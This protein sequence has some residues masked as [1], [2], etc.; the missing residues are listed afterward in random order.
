MISRAMLRYGTNRSCIRELFEYGKQRR[1]VV[2]KENVYDFS[3]GNPSVPAPEEVNQAIRDII[4]EM[5]ST[6]IHGYTSGP[7]SNEARTAIINNLNK[8]FGTDY[9]FTDL[10]LTAGAAAALTAA[11]RALTI[12]DKTEFIAFAP[13][14]TEYSCFAT[15]AGAKLIA[16]PADI[17]A[18]QINFDLLERSI[19]VNTQGVIVNSPNNPSGVIYTEETIKELAALL[20]KKSEEFGHPIF[21]I[22]DEPYRELVYEGS[23]PFIPHYYSNTIICYSYSKSL[24]LPGERIGYALVPGCVEEH[25]DVYGAIAGAGR[26]L[27]YVCAPSLMQ[28]VIARCADVK[29]DLRPYIANRELIYNGLTEMGYNCAKPS[30]AFYLFVEA[31]NGDAQ[32]FSDMAKQQ[33]LLIVPGNDFGCSSYVRISYCVDHEMIK[34]SLPVFKKLMD[35]VRG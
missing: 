7:G 22:S 25:D 11:F 24:S 9:K 1:L 12:D 18:F 31:P 17:P 26:A 16:V 27:G 30:G 4:E 13:F 3:L 5:P 19:N 34:S 32:V 29:P 20:K 15:T 10:Y 21:I 35:K 8:R 6:A 33:D 23:V 2:G 14:F 28:L